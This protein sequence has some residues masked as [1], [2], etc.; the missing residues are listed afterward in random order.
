M[1]IA[2][3]DNDK[4]FCDKIKQLIIDNSYV[5]GFDIDMYESPHIF[6]KIEINMIYCFWK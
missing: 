3:L 2:I 5:S 4:Y 1:K 6:W